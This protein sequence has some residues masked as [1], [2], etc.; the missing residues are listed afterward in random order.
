MSW[1]NGKHYYYLSSPTISE[2]SED[3]TSTVKPSIALPVY[4]EVDQFTDSV[5][6]R[7]GFNRIHQQEQSFIFWAVDYLWIKGYFFLWKLSFWI[8]KGG[9]ADSA[10][11][12]ASNTPDPCPYSQSV[13]FLQMFLFTGLLSIS[14]RGSARQLFMG[15]VES[16]ACT[17]QYVSYLYAVWYP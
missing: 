1:G 16:L 8:I 3:S 14:L 5:V 17:V 15:M 12:A 4:T 6:T 9:R 7:M 10:K 2:Y 11:V 13:M